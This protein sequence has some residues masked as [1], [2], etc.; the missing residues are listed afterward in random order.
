MYMLTKTNIQDLLAKGERLTLECKLCAN[1]LPNSLWETYSA[2]ANSYGG[3]ILLGIEEHRGE[4]DPSK[5]YTIHGVSDSLKLKTDFWNLANDPNKISKNLLVDDDVQ[6]VSVDG[7]D[8][9]AIHIPQAPYNV[10]PVVVNQNLQHGVYKRNHEGDYHCSDNELRMMLRDANENGNDLLLLEHYTMD[11]IDI[12][13]LRGYRQMFQTRNP[14]HWLNKKDDKEFL[15]QLGGYVVNR[16]SGEEGLTM[17]GLL[18]FGKGLPIRER[19]DN[20]RFDYVDKTNLS[21]E[22]RYSDRLT[23]DLTWENNLF[24]FFTLTI[25]RLTRDLPRPFV[26]EGMQRKDDTP[27]HRMIRE[28]FTN[29]IIHADFMITGVLK[30]EKREDGFF[31]SN[32]GMLRLPIEDIYR[33]GTSLARNPHMQDMM[34]MI[35]F[36][37]NLG[38]GF[39]TI[40]STWEKYYHM[41]PILSEH[42]SIYATELLLPIVKEIKPEKSTESIDKQQAIYELIKN[43]GSRDPLNEPLNEPLNTER[44]ASLLEIPYS[45]TKR[46]IKELEQQGRIVRVGSKKTGHWEIINNNK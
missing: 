33:G 20:I 17:A 26:L 4:I 32:P 1:K 28:A 42:A 14:D 44:I 45:T 3:Y 34:R 37:E 6:I 21:G 31:F 9:I 10:R 22:M 5:R 24:Q 36:G 13:S 11:D 15:M 41:R 27:A 12:E 35:G 8:I 38:T 39:P 7:D 19:F 40:V 16:Q 25:P 29:M 2:F 23:Y 18:M 46:I 30:V 43:N